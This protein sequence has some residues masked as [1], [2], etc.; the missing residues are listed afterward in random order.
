MPIDEHRLLRHLA[1]AIVLKLIVLLALWWLFF[2]GA[3]VTVDSE[4]A[5]EKITGA[6]SS[7]GVSK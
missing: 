1:I 3:S 6:E 7:Q 5:A 2:R 4:R